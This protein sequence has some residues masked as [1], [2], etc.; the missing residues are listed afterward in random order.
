MKILVTG[1]LFGF[2]AAS[3]SAQIVICD[4]VAFVNTRAYF[5]DGLGTRV[6]GVRVDGSTGSTGGERSLVQQANRI[7]RIDCAAVTP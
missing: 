3:A 5:Y 6:P 7:I 4:N 2:A 1:L